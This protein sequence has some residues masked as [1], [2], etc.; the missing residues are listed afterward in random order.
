[1]PE[2]YDA[3]GSEKGEVPMKYA[4]ALSL[5]NAALYILKQVGIEGFVEFVHRCG[6]NS[7]IV[8]FPAVALGVSDISL[9]EMMGAY[10]MFP[11]KGVHTEP[12][13][14][15]RIEDKNGTV[16]K[17]FAP[18]QKEIISPST[19]YKMVKMMRGVL[20]IGTGHRMRYRYGLMNEIAGKTGTTN[21]QADAWF[22]GYT[23]QL[24]AGAW[25]GC[26]DRE[27]RFRSEALG[28][29]AAAA[30][31]IW[32]YFMKR[33]YADKSLKINANA[34]FKAPP[35]FDDC[36]MG[37]EPE[38][39]KEGDENEQTGAPIKKDSHINEDDL[40]KGE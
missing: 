3:G 12:Y 32:A 39:V 25:V 2:P 21:N 37:A 23:P 5:N 6:I 30:L 13:F 8:K 14:L 36:G 22:L 35:G 38:P 40:I 28:Q 10:S 18:T 9:Y 1:M 11:G 31:P 20:D 34:S 15:L 24:L 16:I 29:G 27:F 4:L 26:D 33:V 7:K 17:N 19:A